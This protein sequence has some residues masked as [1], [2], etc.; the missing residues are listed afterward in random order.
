MGLLRIV[1]RIG[2]RLPG[3]RQTL[4]YDGSVRRFELA[5]PRG[6][7]RGWQNIQIADSTQ[8]HR[9]GQRRY[10][11]VQQSDETP[12]IEVPLIPRASGEIREIF[13]ISGNTKGLALIVRDEADP[14]A[15]DVRVRITRLSRREA[16]WRIAF[17]R[18]KQISKG[19]TFGIISFAVRLLRMRR[20]FVQRLMYHEWI[21][22]Y[23]RL[24]AGEEALISQ[25]VSGLKIQPKFSIVVPVY[26]TSRHV[27]AEMVSSV[28]NQIY[29]NWELCLADDAS[30]QPH[31][32]E[33]LENLSD[34]KGR[35]KIVLREK[36]GGI[37]EA[38]NS[39]LGLADG[40][41]IT[42]LDHDDVLPAHALAT[43][44]AYINRYPDSDIFYSDED[45]LDREGRRYD[46]FFKPDWN[47]ER[48]YGQNYLNHLTVI[49]AST[50]RGLG[51]LRVG[52]EGSQDY[53]L[54]LR[55]VSS[56]KTPIVHVPH[57]LYHW[58]IYGNAGTFSSTQLDRATAAARKAIA[59]HFNAAG[60]VVTVTEAVNRFHRVVRRDP[61]Q[62]P[63]VSIIIPTRDRADLLRVCLESLR[64][65]DYPDIEVVLADNES[66]EVETMALFES[67]R[68]SGAIVVDCSGPFNY[69]R[70]N[71]QAVTTAS[72]EV[73]LLLNNDTEI[74]DPSWLKEMVRYFQQSDVA[75]VGAKLLYSDRT[76]RQA[77]VVLGMVGVARH[78]YMSEPETAAGYA[79]S[80]GLAQDV[81][82]VT[83]AC[84]AIRKSVFVELGGFN[85]EDLQ[86][87][88]NDVDLCIRIRQAGHRIIFA[89]FAVLTHHESRSRGTDTT[90]ENLR[91]FQ[92]E[93]R[94]MQKRWGEVLE[95]DPFHHPSLSLESPK[96]EL[97]FPPRIAFP[98]RQYKS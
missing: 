53:D 94:Y 54:V 10:F 32:R 38:T 23:D 49:R 39:A 67:A 66:V 62:W 20:G 78:L 14:E 33:F 88:F 55:A 77:G 3:S 65:T 76:I 9:K 48:L 52:V 58:R 73:L 93:I 24:Y 79:G 87:A 15:G 59:D 70:I 29:E 51:G 19:E 81:S 18:R 22:R 34:D 57:I 95:R 36:N 91:R 84:L 1:R 31:V 13:R 5:I 98:W 60:Q 45:K 50:V 97:A 75:A 40:D 11:I 56:T 72:G 83:G 16:L 71:N 4:A 8:K 46:H 42:F 63:R 27:L 43:M 25:F 82:C 6:G 12:E 30:P 86:V 47:R 89:P 28:R 17:R 7:W 85:E 64:K 26:N 2:A 68:R 35:I 90:G 92:S 96:I 44:A 80:L 69:S 74:I 37:S 41:Y 21:D 61:D